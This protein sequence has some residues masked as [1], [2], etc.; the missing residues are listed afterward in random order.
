MPYADAKYPASTRSEDPPPMSCPTCGTPGKI[1]SALDDMTQ[2]QR[3]AVANAWSAGCA[4]GALGVAKSAGLLSVDITYDDAVSTYNMLRAVE[5][6][7]PEYGNLASRVAAEIF[8]VV[9]RYER[10]GA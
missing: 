5:N 8:A 7:R 9:D 6:S 10:G 1:W 4:T 3:D 2:E